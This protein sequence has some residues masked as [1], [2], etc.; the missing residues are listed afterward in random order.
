MDWKELGKS[1]TNIGLP[2]IGAALPIPGGAAI[3][4]ALASA[5]GGD[6]SADDVLNKLTS[7]QELL[8]KAK[9]FELTHQETLLK[10]NL[11]YEV[12]L[13]K[14]DS[15]NTQSVNTTIQEESK[16]DHWPT[17][18][19]RPFIGFCF[20]INLLVTSLTVCVIYILV[21]F[22]VSDSKLLQYIPNFLSSMAAL[23]AV[24]MPILGIASWFRGRMQADPNIPTDNRG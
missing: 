14:V 23:L 2:L 10:L 7:N 11:D 24:P 17:Y 22:G 15:S 8:L 6:G 13:A 20:G 9:E 19:W 21:I 18:T 12:E 4:A 1:L 16:S 3:G 5:I